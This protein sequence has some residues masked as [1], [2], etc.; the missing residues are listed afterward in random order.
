[1]VDRLA[2]PQTDRPLL[3]AEEDDGDYNIWYHRKAGKRKPRGPERGV[4]AKTR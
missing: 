3:D 1:M 2:P 4:Q